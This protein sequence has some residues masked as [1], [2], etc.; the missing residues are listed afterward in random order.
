[1]QLEQFIF[2]IKKGSDKP[3]YKTVTTLKK[4]ERSAFFLQREFILACLELKYNLSNSIPCQI[5]FNDIQK[6]IEKI[7]KVILKP[8]LI[9]RLLPGIVPEYQS[10]KTFSFLDWTL[11]DLEIVKTLLERFLKEWNEEYNYYYIFFS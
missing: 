10:Y 11:D 9:K 2:R 7:D 6:L 3:T 5:C 4:E 8:S 1:M